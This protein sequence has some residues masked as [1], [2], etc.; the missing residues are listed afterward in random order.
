MSTAIQIDFDPTVNDLAERIS[1]LET[2]ANRFRAKA[3]DAFETKT[4]DDKW[5][6]MNAVVENLEKEILFNQKQ[7]DQIWEDNKNN[8]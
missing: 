8:D 3:D 7:L 6:Q 5:A 1:K 2:V 4:T